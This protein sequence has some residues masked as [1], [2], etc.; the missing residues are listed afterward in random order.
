[1]K[2]EFL[3]TLSH[4][5]R[6]P[7]TA[8][9]GWVHILAAGHLSG[10]DTT[11]AHEAILRNSR[12]LADLVND[13][14]D[15]SRIESGK[16]RLDVDDVD[17]VAVVD[18][19]VASASP[20]IEAKRLTLDWRRGDAPLIVRGDPAR[21]QQIVGNLLGNSVRFTPKGGHIA[22]SLKSVQ[23]SAEV[24]VKD[25][26]IGIHR[27]FLPHVF[28]RFRQADGSTTRSYGGLGLG[29]AIARQ[30][31]ERHG[32][33]ITAHSDGEGLGASFTVR[34]P[35]ISQASSPPT[36]PIV[37]APR[38]EGVRVLAVDDDPDVCELV[39][40]VLLASGAQVTTAACVDDALARL[41]E[42]RF[43]VLVSD[44]G[45]PV[46][47][48]Y[49]LIRQVRENNPALPAIALTALARESDAA[50]ALAAG[51]Q[52][53]LTK[54]IETEQLVQAVAAM[55]QLRATA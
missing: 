45:M 44:L 31:T 41:R 18:A 26:G 1:V 30:L 28:D 12:L 37:Q 29:L 27:D 40:R 22:V 50:R 13:L 54:P 2:D 21:L 17:L 7:L 15:M 8:I 11:R 49:D 20:A 38:L 24:T 51:F 23:G 34:L 25:T 35:V 52:Q 47:D 10:I 36:A 16:L 6:T 5:L 9:T 53:H 46:R 43:D 4:E 32:A 55:F 19:A 48:G 14:L 42:Q 3:A 39:K 33:S